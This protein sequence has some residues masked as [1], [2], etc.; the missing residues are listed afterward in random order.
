MTNIADLIRSH[1]ALLM[2]ELELARA[3][4]KHSTQ[5]GSIPENAVISLFKSF[6]PEQIG[7]TEGVVIDSEGFISN[8]L[9]IILYDKPKAQ[10]FLNSASTKV[11]PAEFVYCIGEIKTSI[12]KAGYDHFE[13][14]QAAVKNAQRHYMKP[15]GKPFLYNAFGRRWKS[16]PI[17]SFLFCF[18]GD[19]K[20][21]YD[22]AKASHFERPINLCIDTIVCPGKFHIRR[23]SVQGPDF[24]AG[25]P[26]SL[27][28]TYDH[29][30]FMF[31]GMFATL[32]AQWKLYRPVEIYR[33]YSSVKG[34]P[35]SLITPLG[36]YKVEH[37][38]LLED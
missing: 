35:N 1:E 5:K 2:A 21:V 22:W 15:E 13:K 33:Y 32:A 3:A 14:V 27:D 36:P 24:Y 17:A 30:L 37:Q 12:D 19:A 18:E 25:D 11:I 26:I 16:H 28:C 7:V 20:R 8:Q 4:V 38:D 34:L 29:S 23:T 31:L 10:L 6:L 9:D